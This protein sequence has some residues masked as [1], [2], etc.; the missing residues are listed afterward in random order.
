[1]MIASNIWDSYAY[2]HKII[3]DHVRKWSISRQKYIINIKNEPFPPPPLFFS[4]E[5]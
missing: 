4:F 1:M 3:M 2:K 5:S